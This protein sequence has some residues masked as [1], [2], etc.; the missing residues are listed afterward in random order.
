MSR[1]GRIAVGVLALWLIGLAA[2][3]RRELFRPMVE[4]LAMAATRVAPGGTYFAVH[5]D[6]EQ[7]GFAS[8]TID[9]TEASIV[10]SD[11][12]VAELPVSGR[13]QRASATTRINLSRSLRLRDFSFRLE[14][15][16]GPVETTGVIE[17][18]STLLLTTTVTGSAPDTQRV[19]VTGPVLLPTLVP[20]VAALTERP[21]VG[22]RYAFPVFDPL[23]MRVTD[24][25]MIV[26]AES[27]FVVADSARLNPRTERWTTALQDT[28][29][30]WE[31]VPDTSLAPVSHPAMYLAW[32]VDELGRVVD[33]RQAAGMRLERTAYEL[34]FENWRLASADR[35]RGA[36]IERDVLEST[37]IAAAVPL[38]G[39]RPARLRVRLG[40][41]TLQGFDLDG[42]RQ[43]LDGS[44]LTVVQEDSSAMRAGWRL[45]ADSARFAAE[46]RPELLIQSDHR[47]IRRVAR[48]LRRNTSDPRIVAERINTWVH[49]NVRKRV[50]VGVPSALEVLDSRS[51]DCNEHTQLFIALA[52]AAGIPARGAAGLAWVDGKFYYHAWPEVYLGTWVAVDPTFGQ[53]PADAAHLRFTSG[54][55]TRQVELLRL[56][57]N[58]DIDVLD[59]SE[60]PEGAAR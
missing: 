41:V 47:A 37:A 50:T 39:R 54:G 32:W 14:A 59:A 33:A 52:R 5:Q 44:T 40:G 4:R 8:T 53:F 35:P 56:I 11:Y 51:G 49:R 34:A 20:L 24:V 27:L 55:V 25:Q 57:G 60:R 58:L 3:A 17:N 45:P 46:L 2:L 13:Y 22:T 29:R 15:D 18:D 28:V 16:G 19:K 38:S 43:S 30:A 23:A 7:I 12:F 26:R 6:G 10:V 36:A 9:T 1:R 21:A 31:L 42:G 48:D